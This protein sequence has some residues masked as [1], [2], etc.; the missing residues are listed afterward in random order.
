MCG[1]AGKVKKLKL[2]EIF[3]GFG[4]FII[5]IEGVLIKGEKLITGAPEALAVLREAKIRPVFLSNI[6]D[7]TGQE[8]AARLK[9]SG[10]DI[11]P[12]QILTSALAAALF[13]AEKHPAKK[14]LLLIGSDSFRQELTDRGFNMVEDH[15][16]ADAVVVGLDYALN[17]DKICAAARAIKK[18]S[19]FIA[20]NLAKI[21]L[22]ADNYIVGP[23]FVAMGLAFVTGKSPEVVGKPGSFMFRL[24]LDKLGLKPAEVLTIGDKLEQDI[25]GGHS[26]G[27]GTC[28]VLSGAAVRSDIAAINK[29]YRPDFVLESIFE[30]VEPA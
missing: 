3:Q 6:S 26:M 24:A 5:D 8:V 16:D 20:A 19:L 29:D 11:P 22:T 17:Y 2:R 25:Y 18:G 10:L 14:N 15:E 30:L 9:R 13:L 21:K 28:L 27:T 23:G 1:P 12:G 4:G 7:L